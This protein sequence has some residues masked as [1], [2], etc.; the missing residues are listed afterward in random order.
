VAL[1]Q[2]GDIPAAVEA[3]REAE[4]LEPFRALTLVAL[5]IALNNRDLFGDAKPILLRGLELEPDNV[6]ALAAIAETEEGLD[7]LDAADAHVARAL[8]AAPSHPA[9][10]LVA[11][12]VLMKRSRYADARTALE[13]AVA[14]DAESPKAYYQLS[15]AC[16]RLGDMA[17][18]TRY[19]ER[20]RE[21]LRAMEA[22]V[23]QLRSATGLSR[24]GMRP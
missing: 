22:R 18:S 6:E 16:A 9:A 17:A 24:G 5:G 8:A 3:L 23:E 20:Y 19:R 21:K 7:E 15:L 2:A 13:R 11:G 1:M 4:R 14:L 12:M 10:N